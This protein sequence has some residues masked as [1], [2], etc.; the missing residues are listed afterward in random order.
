MQTNEQ[1]LRQFVRHTLNENAEDL[2]EPFADAEE[3]LDELFGL[4]A[5]RPH[6]TLS[7]VQQISSNV[8]SISDGTINIVL[9][10]VLSDRDGDGIP[11]IA[12]V[13]PDV[14]QYVSQHYPNHQ[15]AHLGQHLNN[16]PGHMYLRA[17]L[18]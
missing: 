6:K 1:Q 16:S 15:I 17:M 18:K 5:K 12:D 9:T 10:I 4:G 3:S 8:V 11:D 7:P 13:E 2:N 14:A